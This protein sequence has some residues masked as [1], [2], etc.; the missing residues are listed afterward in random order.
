MFKDPNMPMNGEYQPQSIRG[1]IEEEAWNPMLGAQKIVD[2]AGEL[3]QDEMN[4]LRSELDGPMRQEFID[5]N[6]QFEEEKKV[7]A[8]EMYRQK[9][10]Y[11]D[12][13]T[14]TAQDFLENNVSNAFI[15]SPIG[16]EI[17]G[18]LFKDGK[19]LVKNK[20][21]EG[22]QDC[23]DKNSLGIMLTDYD[24]VNNTKA[25]LQENTAKMDKLMG[26]YNS[27]GVDDDGVQMDELINNQKEYE[28]LISSNPQKWTSMQQLQSK[29][30]KVDQSTINVLEDARNKIYQQ[31]IDTLPEDDHV[32]NDEHTRQTVDTAIMG[33]ANLQSMIFD[34]MIP[35]FQKNG[36]PRSFYSDLKDHIMGGGDGGRTYKDFGIT[37]EMIGAGDGNADGVID[38]QEAENIAQSLIQ[39]EGLVREQLREYFVQ[40][41]RNNY[42]LG[43]KNRR[44][45][46]IKEDAGGEEKRN[47]LSSVPYKPQSQRIKENSDIIN[48]NNRKKLNTDFA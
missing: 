12:L 4:S 11:K 36:A 13:R 47:K 39:N 9:E 41:L 7:E 20:C 21:P 3:S 6:N 31:G 5:G 38:D 23:E 2:T 44:K 10:Q 24:L 27:G 8:T 30:I 48:K 45:S 43:L 19:Q 16:N 25:L 17:M 28:Q 18:K 15:Q 42:E 26:L 1:K 14:T 46:Y 37:D 22:V 34:G 35:G 32:F 33:K 29:I 40:Y